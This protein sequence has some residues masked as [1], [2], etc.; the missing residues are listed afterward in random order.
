MATIARLAARRSTR[1][2]NKARIKGPILTSF[3][4]V[5]GIQ[6]IASACHWTLHLP[7]STPS[8]LTTRTFSSSV[9]KDDE[10]LVSSPS[11]EE[12]YTRKTPIEHVLLRPGMYVGPNERMPPSTCW[13]LESSPQPI[14]SATTKSYTLNIKSLK[15]AKRQLAIVPALT[16][17][18]DEILVNASD[19][20]LRDDSCT[21]I[22]VVIDPGA[23]DRPPFIQIKNN[24]KGIP[25]QVHADEGV[26]V[27]EL[28]FGTLLS[29]SNFDDN[30]KRLTGGRHGYGA[31]LTNIF[32]QQFTVETLDSR[33]GLLYQQVWTKNMML[34]SKPIITEVTD[35]KAHDYTCVS[36]IPDLP[37]LS[38]DA[39]AKIIHPDDYDVMCR[40]VLDV[41]GCAAG[42]VC[43]TLNGMDVSFQ[44]FR[45]Y[46]DMYRSA[47][48]PPVCYQKVNDRWAVGIG[49]SESGSLEMHSFVNGMATTRGGTHV[50]VILQQITKR[51]QD[52]L[53]KTNPELAEL[54]S[55]GLIRRHLFVA[56]DTLIEN[57]T[58]D[59]QMKESLTSNPAN[60]G[61]K[62]AFN[63][64]F[65]TALFQPQENG[66][67]GVIEALLR[68]AQG[69][70]QASLLKEVGVKKTRRQLL[71]I[72]KLEDAHQAGTERGGECTLILTEG[73]SAKALAVAGFEIIGRDTYGV[74]PLRGK[75]LNVRHATVSQLTS[76]QEVKALCSILGLDFHLE[77]DTI[78]ERKQ[79]R[80]GSVMLMTD[81]DNDGSHIK[82]LV[83]NFFR[84][85]WPKLLMPPADLPQDSADENF[86]SSFITPLLKANKKGAKDTHSFYTMA[87]YR[88]WKDSLSPAD[89]TKY[90][91]KYYKG[92]GTNTSVEARDYFANFD[93]HM[94]PFCWISDADGEALDMV[95]DKERAAERRNWMIDLYDEDVGVDG[96]TVSYEDFINKEM[97]H[98]SHADN[99][100]SLP[101]VIDGLKPSQRKVLYACFKRKLNSEMKVAQL[102]GYCA[103]HTAYHHG[104][105][106]LQ[107]TIIGMAQ[108]FVGSNNINLLE[109]RGQFGTRLGGGADAASPRYIFTQLSPV[110]RLLFPEE[111]DVLLTYL[112]DD[113]QVI[114][115]EFFCPIIPLLLVNGCQ[116]IG[117]GW[118]TFIPPH[119]PRD[120][121]DYVRV[122]LDKTEQVPPLRPY[123][124]G[125]RGAIAENPN[126]SGFIS[127]GAAQKASDTTVVVNELPLGVWTNV[128]KAQLIKMRDRGEIQH[129]KEEHTSSQV[130]FEIQLKRVQLNRMMDSGLEHVL[131]LKRSLPTT[132]MNAFDSVNRL[133]KFHSAENIVDEYFP[134]RLSL[135]RDRRSVLESE[136][137][138][139]S[140]ILQNK[141]RFIEAVSTG[142]I[143]LTAGRRTKDETFLELKSL[144]YSTA[145]ELL[146]IR[147]DNDVFR[148]RK[149]DDVKE[150]GRDDPV[151]SDYDY[152]LNMPLSSLTSERISELRS[153]ASKKDSELKKIQSLTAEDLW[154]T[155]LD[156]LA[157]H[158]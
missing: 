76:N 80:Y 70:Q 128:Y 155:D 107:S 157:K 62:Y 100:R 95:F 126:G 142:K 136:Y 135:Y 26:Y 16:K 144:E 60:F 86:L 66:G 124:R 79:L 106:S 64:N 32:S 11:I 44:S 71:S 109:P 25:V 101:S 9:L 22:D 17:I 54:V 132:N 120:L 117:T 59:S 53:E 18:F 56:C 73:D 119:N 103:E 75:F 61:C 94:R 68:A 43:V 111:D 127:I 46:A 36:F 112:E 137:K 7:K 72:P 84:H 88:A 63:E 130:K 146:R 147:N 104:E 148:R 115:P 20:R 99:L 78:E 98:F 82:G 49:L 47:D 33:N 87:E 110:A 74:F 125:F 102:S 41:A 105:V 154:R 6:D 3:A 89:A 83:I 134:V 121:L 91:I 152:L 51:L 150:L 143:Q 139:A 131:K 96:D 108:D 5:A 27:P 81:Q 15:M 52:K 90:V 122:K 31:K 1:L 138:H 158:L 149:S 156:K 85:F 133:R 50:N 69:R 92:L 35:F 97:I 55:S 30:E 34:V 45:N 141:A 29:G 13:V 65:F 116:G 40:R 14:T 113:G 153:D 145:D 93:K 8:Q 23:D 129:F 140:A 38:G 19:N 114:E 118:S 57:P 21:R 58:F 28:L 48:A 77:Y 151:R 10:E 39:G 12:L 4:H 37:R 67:P 2:A 123:A 24:G 42:K